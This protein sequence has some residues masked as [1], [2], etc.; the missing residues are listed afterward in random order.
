MGPT[1]G[2]FLACGGQRTTMVALPLVVVV[3]VVVVVDDGIFLRNE[4]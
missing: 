4:R 3:V 1:L 2:G